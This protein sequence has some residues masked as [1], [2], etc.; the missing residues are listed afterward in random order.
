MWNASK[1]N[2]V[3][4]VHLVE[5]NIEFNFMNNETTDPLDYI[6]KRRSIRKYLDKDVEKDNLVLLL[7][8][9]MAAPTAANKQPWEFIVV[10]TLLLNIP[11]NGGKIV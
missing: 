4:G 2:Y 3:E 10:Y 1:T 9:A 5:I 7:K 8:A 11:N 6:F